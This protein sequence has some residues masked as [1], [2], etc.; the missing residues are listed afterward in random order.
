M[1]TN[2]NEE[3]KPQVIDWD[4]FDELPEGEES[5]LD[6][7]SDA[8][9]QVAPPKPG[10][11]LFK[12]AFAQDNPQVKYTDRQQVYYSARLE[13]TLISEDPDLNDAKVY[14]TV[15]TLIGRGK[16]SSTMATLMLKG[17][18]K[19]TSN[20]TSD[21]AVMKD[22]RDWILS[23]PTIQAEVDWQVG[24]Q[25]SDNTWSTRYSS[26]KSIPGP[27]GNKPFRFEFKKKDGS[28]VSTGAMLVVKT[29]FAKGTQPKV[30]VNGNNGTVGQ[31][32]KSIANLKRNKPSVHD[33]EE[34]SELEAQIGKRK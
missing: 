25:D 34:I 2:E 27:E 9:E 5:Q 30:S 24:F 6:P 31:Q 22:F 12:V 32:V 20:T 13:L 19:L 10:I 29:Y 11:Y 15:T 28:I 8:F 18:G 1:T 16:N 21:K 3:L 7:E 23:E 26:Y 4:Q 33:N 17:G 14:P